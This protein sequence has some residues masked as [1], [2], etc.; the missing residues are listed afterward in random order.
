[1]ILAASPTH[2]AA[3][4]MKSATANRTDAGEGADPSRTALLGLR[5]VHRQIPKIARQ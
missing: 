2:D 4:P 1:M 3:A 5:L